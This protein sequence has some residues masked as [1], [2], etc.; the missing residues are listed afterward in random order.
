MN[1]DKYDFYAL[2]AWEAQAAIALGQ[3][4]PGRWSVANR[5][6]GISPG[7]RVYLLKQGREP[8]GIVASGTVTSEIYTDD[9]FDPDVSGELNYVEVAWTAIVDEDSPLPLEDLK[10]AFPQQH[11]TPM[12][13]GQGV[14]AE[15]AADLAAMWAHFVGGGTDPGGPPSPAPG[16]GQGWAADA[17]L[18]KQIEDAAQDRLMRHFK[19]G[20][21]EVKDVR[22]TESYDALA[23]KDG[24]TLY[25]EAKGTTGNANTVI[26]TRSE[27]AHARRHPGACILG[28]VSL[29]QR[30]ENGDI[31][32]ESG[33]FFVGPFDPDAGMLSPIA[34]DFAPSWDD[35]TSL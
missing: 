24:N 2:D 6:Q 35:F 21:W 15:V 25:L 28:I 30:D 22:H 34:Y 8:R 11:W 29:L 31:D 4:A 17:E 7:D 18:R 5:V 32:P 14:R 1:P 33:E 10:D 19:G 16:G 23:T 9:H 12:S 20:G 3:E 13:S 27:V 26:V